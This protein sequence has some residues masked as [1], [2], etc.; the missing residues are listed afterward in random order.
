MPASAG[1]AWTSPGTKWRRRR[2][3]TA[4]RSTV[5]VILFN[6]FPPGDRT[7][8]V[9]ACPGN[10]EVACTV[11]EGARVDF[12]VSAVDDCD[13]RPVVTSDFH[14]GTLFPPG[15]TT[16]ACTWVRIA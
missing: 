12:S 1:S 4:S 9:T 8:P 14:S 11:S 2:E 15:T 10:I 7:A 13:P 3:P 16:V 5:I 6:Q